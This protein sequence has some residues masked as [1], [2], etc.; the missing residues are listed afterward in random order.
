[1]KRMSILAT[2]V[3]TGLLGI[4]VLAPSSASADVLCQRVALNNDCPANKTYG[5]GAEFEGWSYEGWS[6]NVKI[7]SGFGKVTC[8][9]S[10][11]GMKVTD[12]GGGGENAIPDVDIT[13][14]TLRNCTGTTTVLAKGYAWIKRLNSTSQLGS[15][16]LV[17]QRVATKAAWLGGATQYDCTFEL[18]GPGTLVGPELKEGYAE[19]TELRYDSSNSRAKKV[20]G[21]FAC[22]N[23]PTFTATYLFNIDPEPEEGFLPEGIYVT[24]K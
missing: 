21:G 18:V 5:V 20:A 13:L 24:Q 19:F 12:A 7:T 17:G 1:M 23:E 22:P 16:N 9:E 2:L 14:F 11:L 3:A 15:F 10:E 6:E 8:K 4:A